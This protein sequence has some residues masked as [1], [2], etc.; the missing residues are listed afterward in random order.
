[1]V[2]TKKKKGTFPNKATQFKRGDSVVTNR[3]IKVKAGSTPSAKRKLAQQLRWMKEKGLDDKNAERLVSLTED[4]QTSAID[5]L[6]YLHIM[7]GLAGKDMNKMNIVSQ[8]FLEWH[9]AHHG[10]KLKIDHNI[11]ININRIERINVELVTITKDC[12]C[13]MPKVRKVLDAAKKEE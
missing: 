13:C 6:G 4:A 2:A 9:K 5:I 11:D 12:K 7:K 1:M 10:G 8:R 3:A